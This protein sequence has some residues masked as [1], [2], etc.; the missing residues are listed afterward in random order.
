MKDQ[1]AVVGL[2]QTEFARW[3]VELRGP[4]VTAKGGGH[5]NMNVRYHKCYEGGHHA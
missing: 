1:V 3:E 4:G 2:G 5:M